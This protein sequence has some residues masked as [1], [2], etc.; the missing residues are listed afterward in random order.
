VKEIAMRTLVRSIR[1]LGLLAI[2]GLLTACDDG[3]P[4][5]PSPFA[6]PKQVAPSP[7]PTPA[8]MPV[9][10]RPPTAQFN[11]LD[12]L[13]GETPHR[14]RFGLC[15]SQ[16]PDPG[17]EL[18]FIFDFGDG[19]GRRR[20]GSCQGEHVYDAPGRYAVTVCVTDQQPLPGHEVCRSYEVSTRP[21]PQPKQQYCHDVGYGACPTGARQFCDASPI[22]PT[23]ASQ[24]LLACE[25]CFGAGACSVDVSDC[26]GP[27]YGA[28]GA[29]APHW[30]YAAGCSGA[31]GRV[32][33]LGQSTHTYGRWAN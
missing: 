20:T 9:P 29:G 26:A 2:A 33:R 12:P 7:S 14:V 28:G 1:P 22:K 10:N 11:V 5:A 13:D 25:A 15:G 8:S 32:W 4:A 18:R 27:G 6:A 16:D 23:R 31:A 24:A 17:D 21:K 30:G 3:S 19:R